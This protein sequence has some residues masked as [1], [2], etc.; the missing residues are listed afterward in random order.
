MGAHEYEFIVEHSV[1]FLD[2]HAPVGTDVR[3]WC[4]TLFTFQ[5]RWDTS[6][7]HL[8]ILAQ[9]VRAA[10]LYVLPDDE[11]Q[12]TLPCDFSFDPE[13]EGDEEFL[14]A[15]PPE[16]RKERFYVIVESPAWKALVDAG[17]LRGP[18]AQPPADLPLERV[19]SMIAAL[20]EKHNDAFLV[21]EWLPLLCFEVAARGREALSK[22]PDVQDLRR[23]A[24]RMNVLAIKDEYFNYGNLM[25]PP[26]DIFEHEE[27]VGWFLAL[28]DV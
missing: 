2:E 1:A 17:E 7:T 13:E 5:A 3:A 20:A 22:D 26:D 11:R 6:P 18:D 4:K 14:E 28:E 27:A 12:E 10:Y 8:R 25:I 9:L 23:I 21:R 16:L 15:L 19:V 24:K